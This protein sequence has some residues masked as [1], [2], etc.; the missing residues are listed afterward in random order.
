MD[1]AL[2]RRT[3][4]IS[5]EARAAGNHPFG[6]LLA[7]ADGKILLEQGNCQTVTHD[8]TGHAETTLMRRASQ[9]YSKEF[10]WNCTLYTSC[11]PCVMCSGASYWGNVGRIVYAMDEVNLLKMTG[12][13][14]ENPTFSHPCRIILAG[15][16]KEMVVN[17]PF[18]ELFEEAFE[19]HK[20]FWD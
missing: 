12:N 15:G 4:E 20:G 16:Q 1:I 3:I 17:G 9:K 18:P 19:A 5:K 6:A 8:C 10:L 11:E 2:L 13:N 14:E 7:D